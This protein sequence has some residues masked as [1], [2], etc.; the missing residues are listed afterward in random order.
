MKVTSTQH[1]LFIAHSVQSRDIM[2]GT[3][4]YLV[5]STYQYPE[6]VWTNQKHYSC[7]SKKKTQSAAIKK[8]I[9][10]MPKNIC[11]NSERPNAKCRDHL[12]WSWFRPLSV[13]FLFVPLLFSIR[14]SLNL[15]SQ[16][17]IWIVPQNE[18]ICMGGPSTH[19]CSVCLPQWQPLA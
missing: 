6:M 11:Q 2:Y 13:Q 12:Q 8:N 16:R 4:I 7:N 14:S 10:Y 18:A 3:I 5:N 15:W 1:Q 17:A 9:I 19:V